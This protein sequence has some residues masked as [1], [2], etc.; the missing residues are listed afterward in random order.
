MMSPKFLLPALILTT[1]AAGAADSDAPNPGET[2]AAQPAPASDNFMKGVSLRTLKP[3]TQFYDEF[4]AG[5]EFTAPLPFN[6]KPRFAFTEYKD[7]QGTSR[8]QYLAAGL[9]A[10]NPRE[11]DAPK[12]PGTDRG[13]LLRVNYGEPIV[14]GKRSD[15]PDAPPIRITPVALLGFGPVPHSYGKPLWAIDGVGNP[16][17]TEAAEKLAQSFSCGRSINGDFSQFGA[18]QIMLILEADD[19]PLSFGYSAIR[20]DDTGDTCP[21]GVN[22]SSNEALHA[23]N[24]RM[25]LRI[26]HPFHD[27]PRV[28][29]AMQLY[30]GTPES[31]KTTSSKTV[32]VGRFTV[33]R[34]GEIN[35]RLS[36]GGGIGMSHF[37]QAPCE[38]EHLKVR[39]KPELH[40]LINEL[41]E[42]A[43]AL[44]E[45]YDSSPGKTVFYTINEASAP[46]RY[47]HG[48]DNPG[49]HER[50]GD[51]GSGASQ[52]LA[53]ASG[54]ETAN[55]APRRLPY[56]ARVLMKLPA[57]PGE[58]PNRGV[59]EPLDWKL[60]IPKGYDGKRYELRSFDLR[61]VSAFAP[62]KF[63]NSS[64]SG[65]PITPGPDGTLTLRELLRQAYAPEIREGH[66]FEFD[67]AERRISACKPPR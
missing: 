22:I 57:L 4:V 40:P 49:S 41:P 35:R 42:G 26:N 17:P 14:F 24:R 1:A 37:A 46:T 30:A 50:L 58:W 67:P 48:Q 55:P 12:N 65:R 33:M 29:V 2:T 56:A 20:R 11:G 3:R 32:G 31:L 19:T 36:V 39:A 53:C 16:I 54:D 21:Q 27:A 7:D 13:P 18:A 6:G 8:F 25:A 45:G 60:K 59:A 10:N 34:V 28:S 38:S 64:I 66:E 23:P 15:A 62:G 61:I 9:P 52:I 51:M 43:L 47:L 63:G 5:P 44:G